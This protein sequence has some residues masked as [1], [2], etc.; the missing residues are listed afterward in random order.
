MYEDICGSHLLRK[1][2]LVLLAQSP[3]SYRQ[4][5]ASPDLLRIFKSNN[6]LW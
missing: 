4:L 3:G 6:K 2:S 5:F 1:S